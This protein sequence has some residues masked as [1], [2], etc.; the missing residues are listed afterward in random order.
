MDSYNK[1]IAKR[2]DII[3]FHNSRNRKD[4]A[5]VDPHYEKQTGVSEQV[6]QE[7]FKYVQDLTIDHPKLRE[8]S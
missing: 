7:W 4:L 1:K 5:S 8:S 2:D 6:L 3:S